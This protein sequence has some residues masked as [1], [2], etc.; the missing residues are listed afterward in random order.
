MFTVTQNLEAQLESNSNLDEGLLKAEKTNIAGDY[1]N[2]EGVW[3]GQ[4]FGVCF[5][6]C[7][8]LDCG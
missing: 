6:R 3:S 1:E 5:F 8:V 2:R 4:A 7:K